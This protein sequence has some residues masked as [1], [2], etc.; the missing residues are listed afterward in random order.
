MARLAPA[1]L[2][3]APAPPTFLPCAGAHSSRAKKLGCRCPPLSYGPGVQVGRLKTAIEAAWGGFGE[4]SGETTMAQIG[5]FTRGDDGAFTGTIRTHYRVIANGV[6]LGAG[7]SKVAKDRG[8][9][10]RPGK[11]GVSIVQKITTVPQRT[12]SLHGD[13]GDLLH[14]SLIRV[15]RDSSNVHPAALK[16][17][18]EQHVV[19]HQT[20]RREHLCGEEVGPA[21]SAKW[22]RRL[23]SGAG[24]RP[25]RRRT[26]P[27]VCSEITYPRLAM[28]PAIRS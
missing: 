28:A 13:T 12:P 6:E 21:S 23:R 14:P 17:D 9:A 7:W 5:I 18:E 8:G 27:T 3:P 22:V 25:F 26:L 1:G 4:Q 24:G 20:A 16:M 11:F 10:E 19:G 2:V 15:N